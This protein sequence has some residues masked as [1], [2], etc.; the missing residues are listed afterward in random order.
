MRVT[1]AVATAPAAPFELRSLE[2]AEPAPEE[3]R[4]R[5]VATGVCHTD[6]IVRDQV[7][8]TPLPAVLGHEGAGVVEA[9]GA[10]VTSVRPGD[11]VVLS[12]NSCGRCGNCA[13]GVPA[14]CLSLV[15]LNFSGRRP[16]GTTTLR[17]A[18][19]E[20][21][22]PF[23]GQ[24]SFATHANVAQRCVVKVGSELPL[25]LLGPLGCGVLTGAGAVLNALRP[26]AG[27]SFAVFGSGSVGLA[28]MLA[29][30]VSGCTT[31]IAVDVLEPRRE[32]ARALGA[33]HTVDAATEDPVE[34]VREITGGRG[35]D[36]ALEA[37]GLPTV[38][39]QA[40]DSLAVRGTVGVVG[41]AAPGTETTFETGMSLIK[42][43]TLRT[44]I[45]GDAVPRLFVPRLLELWQRGRFP[46]DRLITRYPFER[47][48]EAFRD[49]ESGA[50]VK[51]VLTFG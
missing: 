3:V 27:S 10:A 49:A 9:V 29:A 11:H 4:V 30:L 18:A 48:N 13:D 36:Y 31:V 15:D 25:D 19:L 24:S 43:W 23:F 7:Y 33:T 44:I 6:A 34:R 41:A 51:P 17:D 20:V 26:P 50:A 46:F 16:D 28:G 35:T 1:A 8:P 12:F 22:S 2:L 42:G 38:L 14:Y 39:R 5:M 37:T 47:I 32:L 40:A 21:S 45:E